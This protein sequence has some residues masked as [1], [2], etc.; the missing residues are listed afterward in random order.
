[1]FQQH[2]CELSFVRSA[3]TICSWISRTSPRSC[4]K[5]YGAENRTP[6]V[7]NMACLRRMS[8]IVLML[9][10]PLPYVVGFFCFIIICLSTNKIIYKMTVF[11]HCRFAPNLN[12]NPNPEPGSPLSR[13]VVL[14]RNISPSFP[15][16]RRHA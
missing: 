4:G 12:P 14:Q 13:I 15:C 11:N 6:R 10:N 9:Y 2:L 8:G 7:V 3:G 16:H 5:W 1:M